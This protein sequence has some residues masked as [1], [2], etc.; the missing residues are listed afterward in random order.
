MEIETTLFDLLSQSKKENNFEEALCIVYEPLALYRVRPVTRCIETMT[1]HTDAVLHVSYSPCGQKLASGGGDCA[2][3]FW[4]VLTSMPQHTCLGH[5]HHILCTAWSP[6]S[7]LFI[8]ADRSGEIRIWD[9]A[10]GKQ[11]GSELKG[12]TKFV[13]SLSFEPY[14]MNPQCCRLIPCVNY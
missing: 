1:G 8:S 3:R 7:Q 9:P 10:T 6:D 11:K 5:K 13:T 12:H 14:H 2:V 4:N